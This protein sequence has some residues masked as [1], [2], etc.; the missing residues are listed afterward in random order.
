MHISRGFKTLTLDLMDSFEILLCFLEANRP[1]KVDVN[2]FE[3]MH[4][5]VDA[6]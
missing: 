3:W 4:V 5:Y 6:S 1:R 2:F